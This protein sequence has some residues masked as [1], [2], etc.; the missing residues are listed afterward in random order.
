MSTELTLPNGTKV[1]ALPDND[2]WTNRFN[3]NSESSNR[4]Y[5]VSQHKKNR[6][7]GC[8]CPGW[9]TR[10]K[11]KHLREIGLPAQEVPHEITG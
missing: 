9:R 11:C 6:H 8:S 4:I 2:Q 3:V 5:V 1:L 10:R 7:W